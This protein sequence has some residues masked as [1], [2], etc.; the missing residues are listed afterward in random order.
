MRVAALAIADSLHGIEESEGVKSLM[1]EARTATNEL[2]QIER[3]LGAQARHTDP[4]LEIL[5][6]QIS[7]FNGV[8]RKLLSGAFSQYTPQELGAIGAPILFIAGVEDVLFPIEAIRLVQQATP[9]SFMVEIND[10][11]HSAFLEQPTQFNDT[12]LTL[13]QM[14]GHIGKAKMAH[15]NAAGYVPVA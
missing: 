7:S 9:G 11:G 5:Y 10:A 3:V 6:G 15:S 8:D 12:I 1:D 4:E 13:L 2:S 14:A